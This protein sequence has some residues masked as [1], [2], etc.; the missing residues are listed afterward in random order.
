ME[1]VAAEVTEVVVEA[2]VAVAPAA[3]TRLSE[4]FI[5][6]EPDLPF[7]LQIRTGQA[8]HAGF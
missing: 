1:V 5:Y 4:S 2:V 6:L 3:V 8:V 7:S